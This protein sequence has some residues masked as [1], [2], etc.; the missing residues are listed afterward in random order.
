MRSICRSSTAFWRAFSEAISAFRLAMSLIWMSSLAISPVR[1]LFRSC[2]PAIIC[3]TTRYQTP[4]IARPATATGSN[5]A[6][7]RRKGIFERLPMIMFCGLPTRVQTLPMFALIASAICN[8]VTAMPWPM[9]ICA[10]EIFV[11]L[12]VFVGE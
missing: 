12:S 1:N 11:H 5:E 2:C 3:W 8:R 9:G 6:E 10:M 7:K 4:T